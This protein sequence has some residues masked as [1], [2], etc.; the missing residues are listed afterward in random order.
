[1]ARPLGLVAVAFHPLHLFLPP[2]TIS[3]RLVQASSHIDGPFAIVW[4]VR[5]LNAMTGHRCVQLRK[6]P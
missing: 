3:F 2:F 5:S 1:M 4:A 6:I